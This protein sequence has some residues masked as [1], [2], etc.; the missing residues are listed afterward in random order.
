MKK[1]W[2]FLS[3][4]MGL[5]VVASACSQS[6]P[7]P[8]PPPQEGVYRVEVSRQGF[9]NMAGEAHL[10][11]E[12]GQEVEITF[13]YGDSDFPQNNP[14]IMAIPAYDITTGTLDRENPEVT[15]RFTASQTGEINFMCTKVDCVGH[16]NLLVGT[17]TIEEEG[18]G[19]Q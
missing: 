12:V 15:V 17:I 10:E 19:H 8:T 11:G 13:V 2:L 16:T 4:L 9:K 3:V 6:P 7:A 14:H 18:H 5:L 1:V